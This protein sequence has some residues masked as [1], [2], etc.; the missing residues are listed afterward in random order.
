MKYLYIL[1]GSGIGGVMR[2]SL[3]KWVYSLSSGSFPAGTLVVNLCGCF[4]IG[5]LTGIFEHWVIS[6]NMRLFLFV[7]ILG[8]FTTF[9]TFGL[10]TF[11]LLREAEIRLA[12]YNL[13]FNG[14]LGIILV[15]AGYILAQLIIKTI[16]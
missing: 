12:L 2:Y 6:P 7:G 13:L 14:V 9:S 8:G 4:I 16:K 15:I 11:N 3:S 1:I 5:F 10:E